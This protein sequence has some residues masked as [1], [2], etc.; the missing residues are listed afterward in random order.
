MT[1]QKDYMEVYGRMFM[2]GGTYDAS[3]FVKIGHEDLV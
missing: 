2:I 1:C 3:S